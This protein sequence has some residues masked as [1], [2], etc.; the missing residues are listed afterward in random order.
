VTEE[1]P[2]STRSLRRRN[3]ARVLQAVR[4]TGGLTQAEI[5]RRSGLSPA[6]VTNLVRELA[7]TGQVEVVDAV[8]NGRRSRL[9]SPVLP[10]GHVLGVDIG[11]SHI[12]ACLAD[13]GQNVVAQGHRRMAP[14]LPAE[15]GLELVHQLY[16]EVLE[17]GG[18]ARDEVLRAGVGVAG[19]LD[20]ASQQIGAGTMLPEWAGR[21]LRER[22]AQVLGLPVSVDNDANLGALGEHAWPP[23]HSAR[24]MVYVRLA[25]GIGGG[26]IL[27]GRLYR[28]ANGVA[29]EIGHATIDEN[30]PLCRCGNRGCLETVASIPGLLRVLASAV[31]RP[32]DVD[33]WVDLV[34]RGHTTAIRLVEELGH[35]LG[36]AVSN[37]C[38]LINPS[39]VLMGGPISAVGEILLEPIR[40]EVR[41]RSMTA[42]SGDLRIER[43]RHGE[44]SEVYGAC[45]LALSQVTG[46]AQDV[47]ELD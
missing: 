7:A 5:A 6:A 19:P 10:P 28:G 36:V 4:Q 32:V 43:S 41:R 33:G 21:D 13:L 27:D 47:A 1:R 23:G 45:H 44:L 26:L 40:A 39:V 37:L 29:G 35:H 20:Q 9:V 31:D 22:F 12:R 16:Q 25:T 11:R 14:G 46:L 18:V 42:A 30:G 34:G 15:Q 38:N 2:G 17:L 8:L 3:F 24:S